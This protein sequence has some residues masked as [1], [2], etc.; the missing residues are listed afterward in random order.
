[1]NI[2]I[3]GRAVETINGRFAATDVAIALAENY[4][5]MGYRTHGAA[6]NAIS[7]AIAEMCASWS[8]LQM[9]AAKAP[10]I[11]RYGATGGVWLT[12]HQ[13]DVLRDQLAN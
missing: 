1:M 6:R 5:A 8:E 10:G 4:A 3:N 12:Q 7:E 13:L 9:V 11:A 2:T